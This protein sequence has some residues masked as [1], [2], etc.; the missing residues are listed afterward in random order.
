MVAYVIAGINVTDRDDY[1]IYAEQTV[2]SAQKVGGQFLAKG[3]PQTV[4]EGS[5]PDRHVIISF[6]SREV[7]KRWYHSEEYQAILPIALRS[8]S[9]NIVIVEGFE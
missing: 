4:I 1:R 6:P 3:G 8:A 2:A 9:R 7:A 5:A